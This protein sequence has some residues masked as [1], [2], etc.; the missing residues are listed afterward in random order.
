MKSAYTPEEMRALATD[1]AYAGKVNSHDSVKVMEM[2]EQGASAVSRMESDHSEIPVDQAVLERQQARARARLLYCMDY[3]MHHL[4]DEEAMETWLQ[5]GCPDGLFQKAEDPPYD[6][7]CNI[8]VTGDEFEEHLS[9]F[10]RILARQVMPGLPDLSG[11]ES[12]K[13]AL[14]NGVLS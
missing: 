5:D 10:T 7:Y 14:A 11:F 2:L 3:I 1:I 8:C 9:L 13:G 4:S 6:A 12:E